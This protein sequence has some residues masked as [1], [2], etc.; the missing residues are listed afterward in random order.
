MFANW[1][2]NNFRKEQTMRFLSSDE[3]MFD[4]NGM[5]NLQNDIIW[6]VNRVE[7]D[8]K[9]GIKQIEKFPQKVMVWLGMCSKGVTPLI[10]FDEETLDHERYIKEVLPVAEKYEDKVFGSDW[11]YQRDGAKPHIHHLTQQ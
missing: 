4:L 7:A 9:G 2:R 1:I 5:H 3:K 6:A 10:I 8:D 11:T